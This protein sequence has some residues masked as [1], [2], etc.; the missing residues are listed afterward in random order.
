M[1]LA[2]SLIVGGGRRRAFRVGGVSFEE[3]GPY[4]ET[5]G[6][7]GRQS[8]H[9][10]AERLLLA[11]GWTPGGAGDWAIALC[12]PDGAAAARISPFDPAG[13][14]SV[15]LYREAAHTRQVPELFAHRRLVGGGDFQIM[16]WLQP[17]PEHEAVAFHQAIVGREP[18][19]AGLVEVVR[20]IHERARREAPWF[21]IKVD[22]NPANVMR[23]ADGRLVAA[24][25]FGADGPNLY[26]TVANEPELIVTR[27]PESERRFM[28]EIPLTA[29]GPWE[30]EVRDAMRAGLAAADARNNPA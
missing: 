4:G 5:L 1:R 9:R 25:L 29:T 11:A 16:E 7:L 30:P 6:L 27:I 3:A 13:P 14:Y 28:T 17:V 18:E 12:S 21:G 23:A 20:R 2:W 10:D 24:D 22:D 15:A 19:V 8:D 26:A